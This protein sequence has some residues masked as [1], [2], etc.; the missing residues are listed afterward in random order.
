[1]STSASLRIGESIDSLRGLFKNPQEAQ[2]P[3]DVNALAL[4]SLKTFHAELSDH[5]IAVITELAADLPPV[6]GHEGQLRAV[7]VNIVQNAIDE[8]ASLTDRART[9]RIPHVYEAR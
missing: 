8:L 1:M 2:Q 9:L 7:V 6:V 3:I 5:G 4:A